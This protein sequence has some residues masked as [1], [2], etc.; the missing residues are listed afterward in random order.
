MIDGL[1]LLESIKKTEDS[2]S[3]QMQI[4]IALN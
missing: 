2:L 3:T 4:N 1:C